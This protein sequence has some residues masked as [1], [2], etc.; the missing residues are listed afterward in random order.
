MSVK[1]NMY[2]VHNQKVSRMTTHCSSKFK[3]PQ[4]EIHEYTYKVRTN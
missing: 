2:M 1:L 3:R 4:G